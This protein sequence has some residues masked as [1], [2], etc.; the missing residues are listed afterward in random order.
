[1]EQ[2][3]QE[4]AG[5]ACLNKTQITANGSNRLYFRM[6]GATKTCMA[7]YNKNVRENEAFF[8]FAQEMRK[9]GIR[10]PEVYAI[11][12]DRTTYLQQDLGNVT[13]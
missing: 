12:E 13:I 1:M 4:W 6:E 11:S 8:F 2:L 9:R 3:F 7:A 5:E 10:V